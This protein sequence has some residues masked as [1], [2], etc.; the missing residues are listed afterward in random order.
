MKHLHRI[1]LAAYYAAVATPPAMSLALLVL[2]FAACIPKPTPVPVI[3]EADADAAAVLDPW[4]DAGET[5]PVDA[6]K[7]ATCASACAHLLE[8]HCAHQEHC[9]IT[10]N[11]L[12]SSGLSTLSISCLARARAC[13]DTKLC[14]H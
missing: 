11:T 14:T 7:P 5:P 10:C 9:E 1:Y 4:P 8:L 2:T 3:P 13:A 12:V 6:A